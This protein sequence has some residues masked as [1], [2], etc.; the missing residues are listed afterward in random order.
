MTLA[1]YAAAIGIPLA[2]Y[3]AFALAMA[4]DDKPKPDPAIPTADYERV[5][6]WLHSTPDD[7]LRGAIRNRMADGKLTAKEFAELEAIH[8]QL[9]IEAIERHRNRRGA[10]AQLNLIP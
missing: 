2:I 1:R 6:N 8:D 4:A 5:Q 10:E 9:V 7:W 3:A